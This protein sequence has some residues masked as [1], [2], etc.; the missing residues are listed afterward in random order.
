MT[1]PST[2]PS[3]KTITPGAWQEARALIYAH[4]GRL[5]MGLGL[6]LGNRLAGRVLP[7]SSKWVIDRVINRHR[8][9]LLV[10]LALAAGGATLVQAL[11]GFGLSQVVGVAAQR[12]ITD[13][14]R[15][16]QAYV[17]RLPVSYFDSTKSGIL[18]DR[19]MGDAEGIRNLVGTGLVQLV[20]GLVTA[21]I[22]LG[23]LFYLNWRLTVIAIL[24]L[25]CFGGGMAYAFTKLRPLFRDR[26][27]LNAEVTGR[28]GE[29]LGGI[30]IVKA[31]RAEASERLVF[32][33]GVNTLFRNVATTMTGISGL[34]AF[35]TLIIGA[36]GILMILEGGRAILAGAMKL[37]DFFM[38]GVFI[39]LVAFPLIN[40]PSIGTQ[41]TH[42]F[43]GLDRVRQI[44]RLTTRGTVA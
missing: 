5:A 38:Y 20:G 34:G 25:A 42:A 35:A 10:P 29:T 30:R 19:I 28:L 41:I 8:P 32:T 12:A 36:I 3:K 44:R 16:V 15:M 6:L 33:R 21:A 37:G 22:A 27:K 9:E 7:S 31:Y 1:D 14:R 11:T 39:S 17:L 40:I 26:G 43:A 24:I 18:I 2:R 23:V 4:R 13:M